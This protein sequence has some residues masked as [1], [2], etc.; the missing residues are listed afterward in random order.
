MRMC[1]AWA[2]AAVLALP[3]VLLAREEQLSINGSAEFRRVPMSSGG[4]LETEFTPAFGRIEGLGL[5]LEY[6]GTRGQYE[7]TL[8]EG[9]VSRYQ[10]ILVMEDCSEGNYQNV[11]VSW[12]LDT[13]KKYRL[14]V[15]VQ[16]SDAPVSVWVTEGG[17]TPLEEYGELAIDGALVEGQ[18]LS[19]IDYR[20]LPASGRTLLFLFMTWT[21]V[22]MAAIYGFWPK[23][24]SGRRELS[25]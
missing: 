16:G 11:E 5:G 2:A 22:W 6:G 9:E 19:G 17:A 3:C 8:W 18:I 21:G 24:H 23:R 10:S 20:R 7:I 15:E 13:Q 4:R 14:T 12:K 1:C 25:A